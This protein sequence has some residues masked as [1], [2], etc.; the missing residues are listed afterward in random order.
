MQEVIL[1]VNHPVGLHARPAKE[2][3]QQARAFKSKITIQ[4]LSRPETKE[5][6]ISPFNLLQIGVKH[7]HEI[8]LRAAGEDEHEAIAALTALVQAD[9]GERTEAS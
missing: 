5:L 4:N 9:F 1:I 7:G 8:R 2:L 6:P 3:F